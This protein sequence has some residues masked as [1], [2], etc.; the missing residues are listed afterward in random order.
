MEGMSLIEIEK[1]VLNQKVYI[2]K[3]PYYECELGIVKDVF[4]SGCNIE[5]T[6]KKIIRKHFSELEA[7]KTRDEFDLKN[8]Q[9]WFEELYKRWEHELKEYNK[10][11]KNGIQVVYQ[12]A[13]SYLNKHAQRLLE[14][15][16]KNYISDTFGNPKI[17]EI[18]KICYECI[19]G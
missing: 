19:E 5:L 4:Y 6:D 15:I 8:F 1:R 18:Y 9:E 2:K 7:L 14:E 3:D 10:L 13:C 16:I 12:E 17:K 11:P